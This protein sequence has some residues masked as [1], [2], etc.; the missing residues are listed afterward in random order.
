MMT[1]KKLIAVLSE[2]DPDL[3]VFYDDDCYLREVEGAVEESYNIRGGPES[4]D[5][6]S[7]VLIQ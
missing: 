3:K 7:Y 2:L 6:T 1:V 5:E 4:K